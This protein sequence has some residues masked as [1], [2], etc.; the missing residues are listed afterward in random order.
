M[1]RIPGI[2]QISR[3]E[4]KSRVKCFPEQTWGGG[5]GRA[6]SCICE[7]RVAFAGKPPGVR[8]GKKKLCSG[9]C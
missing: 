1:T 3:Q 8:E 4:N 9:V 6:R 5:G 7:R 2:L